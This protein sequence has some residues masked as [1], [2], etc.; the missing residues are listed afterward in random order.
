MSARCG[1]A[2]LDIDPQTLAVAKVRSVQQAHDQGACAR[3]WAME[4]KRRADQL[5]STNPP[6]PTRS[7]HR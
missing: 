1:F 5:T 4:N 6:S 7:E 3:L 2:R